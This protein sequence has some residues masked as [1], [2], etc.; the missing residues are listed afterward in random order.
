MSVTATGG[1]SEATVV[2][3]PGAIKENGCNRSQTFTYTATDACGNT[4]KATTTYTWIEDLTPPVLA[5]VPADKDLGNNPELPTCDAEVTAAD[6]CSEATVVCTPGTIKRDRNNRSQTFLYT[7]TDACGNTAT[8]TTIYTWTES[9]NAP[10]PDFAAVKN[11]IKE[12]E[13]VQIEDLSDNN[14]ESWTWKFKGGKPETSSRKNPEV[15]YDKPGKYSVTLTVTNAGGSDTK[16]VENFITVE[17]DSMPD[18]IATGDGQV[19]GQAFY[20]KLYPNPVVQKLVIEMNSDTTG[21]SYSLYNVNGVKLK[22]DK[23]L[24][25]RTVIDLAKQAPGVYLMVIEKGNKIFREL[26]VKQ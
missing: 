17:E 21:G 1:C 24:S 5:N 25:E 10:I 9:I 6:Q 16:T 22:T 11:R 14:P 20:V 23:I 26:I 13:T 2:C 7:A 15:R 3:T 4:A 18:D 12:G 19:P 8:G